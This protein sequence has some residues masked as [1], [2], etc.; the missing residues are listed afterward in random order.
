M[1]GRGGGH[2]TE[3]GGPRGS[4]EPGSQMPRA[5]ERLPPTRSSEAWEHFIKTASDAAIR[6][7][8]VDWEKRVWPARRPTGFQLM[9]TDEPERGL[10]GGGAPWKLVALVPG[11]GKT[12]FATGVFAVRAIA[13]GSQMVTDRPPLR[14]PLS[15]RWA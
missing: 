6:A 2:L 5:G 1:A 3:A 15:L 12:P 10:E 4:L 9:F 11:P 14:P 8:W 7:A 13:C